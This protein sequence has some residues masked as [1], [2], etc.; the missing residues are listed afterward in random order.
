M[1]S[2]FYFY[3]KILNNRVIPLLFSLD[4][5]FYCKASDGVKYLYHSKW[6]SSIYYKYLILVGNSVKLLLFILKSLNFINLDI[7]YGIYSMLL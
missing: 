3:S 4:F 1:Y 2:Y 5:I 7:F 6:N